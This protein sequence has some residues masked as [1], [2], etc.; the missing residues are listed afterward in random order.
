MNAMNGMVL[1]GTSHPIFIQLADRGHYERKLD[2]YSPQIESP[3]DIT[4]RDSPFDQQLN[5]VEYSNPSLMIAGP[6]VVPSMAFTLPLEY[7]FEVSGLSPNATVLQLCTLFV[8]FGQILGIRINATPVGPLCLCT[9][10]ATIHMYGSLHL[11]DSALHCLNGAHLS[12]FEGPVY[13]TLQTL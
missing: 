11:R 13:V 9:G 5:F 8:Q 6:T 2:S 3:C 1:D 7:V 10:T 12:P 4:L